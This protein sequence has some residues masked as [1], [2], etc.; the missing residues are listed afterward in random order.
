M[1]SPLA[2]RLAKTHNIDLNT[3]NGSGPHGRVVKRDIEVAVAGG[4][5]E[6][7]LVA[8]MATSKP[9]VGRGGEALPDARLFYNEGEYES[10]PLDGMRRAIARRMTQSMSEIPHF[11]L[12]IDCNIDKLLDA[13]RSLNRTDENLKL[14]VNDF[15]VRAAALAL[16]KVPQANASWAGDALLYHHHADIGI[17]VALEGGGLIT[18]IIRRADEKQIADIASASKDLIARARNRKLT[19]Q[20]YEGGSFSLSNLGMYGIRQFTAVI[21][22]PQASILAIGS[23]EKRTIVGANNAITV[24]TLMTVTLSCDHRVIDGAIGAELLGT[25]RQY[26]ENPITMLV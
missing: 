8:H 13:R 14:S 9:P 16:M 4:G 23:G 12:T 26:V 22:P 24:A 17:A 11:Y 2:R 19:P 10:R 15:L 6:H 18:P 7:E 20:D 3:L 25:F 1:A 5:V 21:N